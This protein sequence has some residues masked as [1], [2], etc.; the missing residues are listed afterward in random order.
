MS[1]SPRVG[2]LDTFAESA[3]P[4]IH[5][6]P[7]DGACYHTLCGLDLHDEL[8]TGLKETPSS[9]SAKITCNTCKAIIRTSHKYSLS[10][11]YGD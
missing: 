3:L 2:S 11:L 8:S 6:T 10:D 1:R 5:A 4:E 9:P 7:A